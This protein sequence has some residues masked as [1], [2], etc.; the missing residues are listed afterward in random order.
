MEKSITCYPEILRRRLSNVDVLNHF[1]KLNIVNVFETGRSVGKSACVEDV[2]ILLRTLTLRIKKNLM[3]CLI[4]IIL[5]Q[6]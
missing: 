3:S 5:F 4:H 1:A 6:G 2:R